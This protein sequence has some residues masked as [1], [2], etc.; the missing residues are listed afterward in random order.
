VQDG[1]RSGTIALVVPNTH[2][3]FASLSIP[4]VAAAAAGAAIA[5][6]VLIHLLFRQRFRVVEWA[7]MRFLQATKKNARRRIDRWLLL[8]LRVGTVLLPLLGMIAATPWVEPLWQAIRPGAAETIANGPRTHL[9][10]V[11][12]L[13][14]S[15]SAKADHR[16]RFE[17]AVAKAEAAIRARNPGDGLTL[18]ALGAHAEAVVPGPSN[19][20]EK[21]VAELRNLKPTHAAADF[22]AGLAA[23]NDVLARSPRTFLRRQVLFFTD[24]QAVPWAGVLP[25][26]DAPPPEA[27][28]KLAARGD[29][30]IVDCARE[31]LDNSAIT[32]LALGD[33]L[34]LVGDASTITATVRHFG[35]S[36][37]T[38][39]G[40]ELLLGRPAEPGADS[41]LVPVGRQTLERLE[42][43]DAVPVRFVLPESARFRTAGPHVVQARLVDADDLPADDA[44]A[45]SFEVRDGLP[46]TLV[47]GKTST[48]P[49]LRAT[50]TLADAIAPDGKPRPGHPGRP[51]VVGLEEFSDATL[52]DLSAVDCVFLCDVPTFTPSQ[53]ARLDAVLKRGGGVVFGLGS[54]AAAN[55]EHYNRVLFA[56]GNGL[57][58]G[59]LGEIVGS[60]SADDAGYRLVADDA[61]YRQPPLAAEFQDA[62]GRAGLTAVPFHKYVRLELAPGRGRRI[63]SFAPAS[64]EK[65]DD[66]KPDPAVVEWSRHRGRVIVYTSSFNRDWNDWPILPTYPVFA[67]ELLRFAATNPE[68]QSVRVGEAIEEYL[69]P[70]TVGLAAKLATGDGATETTTVTAAEEGGVA[71]FLDTRTAGLY[72]LDIAGYRSKAIA[73]NV[74]DAAPGGG[75]ESDLRRIAPETLRGIHPSIQ[76]V[77]DPTDIAIQGDDGVAIVTS[78]RPHGPMLARWFVALGLAALAFELWLAW[79]LG[80][81]RLG[82]GLRG[83]V[84]PPTGGRVFTMVGVLLAGA[85]GLALFAIAHASWTGSLLGFLPEGWRYAL[86]QSAG[87]PAAG[88]GEGTRWRLENN[89][90]FGTNDGQ[91]RSIRWGL[92]AI[93]AIVVAVFYGYERRATG[94]TRRILLP[95]SLRLGAYWLAIFLVLPQLRIAFD[96]EGWPDIA[97]VVDTSASMATVDDP[98]DP[99]LRAKL[100]SLAGVPGLKQPQRIQLARWLLARPDNDWLTRLVTERKLKVHVYSLADQLRLEGSIHD[101]GELEG[102]R[103]AVSRLAADG[104]SS[105]LGDGV[106][107]VLKAFRGG[108]LVAIIVLTD[109]ITTAGDDLPRAAREAARADVPLR[110]VGIGDAREILDLAVGDLRSEH[111]VAKN[112]EL[113]FE[114]RLTAKGPGAPKAVRATL[115]EKLGGRL[116]KRDE[117]LVTPDAAGKPVPFRLKHTPTELGERTYVI[118]VPAQP[119]ERETANNVIERTIVVTE[120]R[121]LRVLYVE[122][123]PRY[124]FRFVKVLLERELEPGRREK[125]V[126]LHTLLLD[127]SLDHATTDRAALRGFPTRNELFEYDAVILGD[128]DPARLDRPAQRLQ[129][130]ADFVRVK[131]GGLIVVAGEHAMPRLYFDTPLADVL[132]VSKSSAREMR[133]TSE[134]APL[135]APYQP[136]LT[137]VGAG[138]PIFRFAANETDGAEV[139]R[140]LKPLYWAASG[141]ARKRTAEVLAVHPEWPAEDDPGE[142]HPLALQQFVGA[143]RTLFLGFDETW[144]WRWRRD[145][146]QFNRFWRQAVAVLSRNRVRGIE[147]KTDKQTGYRRDEPIKVTVQFPDDAPPPGESVKVGVERG[148]LRDAT[149]RAIAGD[150]ETRTLTLGK[151]R[152]TRA[153]YEA[154]LAP[155][156]VGEYRFQQT[157]PAP[158]GPAAKAEA[159]VLPPPGERDRLEL[160]RADLARAAADSR[161]AFQMFADAETIVDEL[162]DVARLPLDQPCP[163]LR[164]WNHAVTFALL[165]A[166]LGCEWILRK[167]ER[168]V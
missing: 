64:A 103:D 75:S 31:D 3:I 136:R 117:V 70:A 43:N 76:V 123:Y 60:N 16:S 30:A 15:M 105:R 7:A 78:V 126:D 122:G 47:N 74:A 91:D 165:L 28:T 71:R 83:D 111:V 168:L 143:G 62:N 125:A 128:V 65:P 66:R 10:V 68:R 139:W 17:S 69:P 120:N 84:Q 108:S 33:P 87:V 94:G 166:L 37:R 164:V 155:T 118:E 41:A 97:I 140:R 61:A 80:P 86:E 39:V 48:V 159:R 89:L 110:L 32:A 36:P 142:R 73:V 153:T 57:L 4:L 92:A 163:P 55:L 81:A 34:P 26:P 149:G 109:G 45:L 95:A 137:P 129:D 107:S 130:L 51:K 115:S 54:R 85:A 161:G 11:V 124:E 8:A 23:V 99:A 18:V 162:P 22:A 152:G 1:A 119:G 82:A 145:E 88:P 147:M 114:A 49:L 12:D 146:E 102:V 50:E 24:L 9:V 113:I 101:A 127:A 104:E 98:Q 134:D 25:R 90:S 131:G 148:P 133:P 150:H 59:R 5:V 35:R 158:T 132:P 151:V 160:N 79:R 96:R 46:C 44:R 58:P 2:P 72:R 63:L 135:A 40:V 27:W 138:H 144:R 106:Q 93:A 156:P 29:L 116:E 157:D 141:Y 19:D 112:D 77:S 13:S 100:E 67:G 38:Q 56:E 14:L 20:V 6:P 53:V 154:T 21:T 52:S 42:P 121:R 167:R